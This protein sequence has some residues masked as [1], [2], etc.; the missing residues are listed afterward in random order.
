VN[1]SNFLAELRRRNVYKVVNRLRC[2][3]LAAHSD[4]D[5][6]PLFELALVPVRLNHIAS[7]IVNANDGIMNW[8]SKPIQPHFARICRDN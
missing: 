5:T 8:Y 1:A 4:R 6:S 2:R 3:G 7:I